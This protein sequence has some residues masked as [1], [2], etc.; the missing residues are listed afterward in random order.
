MK[1]LPS[2]DERRWQDAIETGQLG[3]WDLHPQLDTV[4]YP[5]Q[6]K[7]RLGFPNALDADSTS[8]WRCR[9]HPEDLAP[10]LRALLAHQDGSVPTYDTQFRLRSNGSGY[11]L[12]HSRG[13]LVERDARGHA[14]RMLGTMV[15]LSAHPASPKAGLA[16][17]MRA[18]PTLARAAT[19]FHLLLGEQHDADAWRYPASQ[20]AEN[21][22][23]LLGLMGDLLDV[24]VRG[25]PL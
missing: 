10:M 22:D 2:R 6:W 14:V 24:S 20:A 21:R 25:L 7:A 8:F 23:R 3:V 15:D 9:V 4:H 12:M 16:G 1:T 5:P 13:R 17:G 19:P 18:T 11:R